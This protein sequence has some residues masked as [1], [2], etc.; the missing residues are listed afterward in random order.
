MNPSTATA[1]DFS[2]LVS[3]NKEET[4]TPVILSA[5]G[6][7]KPTPQQ[8]VFLSALTSTASHITLR[9]R[10]GCGKTSA[11]LMGVDSYLSTFPSHELL[12]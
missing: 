2:R 1:P 6:A 5:P 4:P 10:A 9:A 7:L 12:I 11:I 3:H 8:S